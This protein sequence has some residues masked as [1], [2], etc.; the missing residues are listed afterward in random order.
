MASYLQVERRRG[1][2][3]IFALSHQLLFFLI[4]KGKTTGMGE[5]DSC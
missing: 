3:L 5:E 4:E 2:R 1:R